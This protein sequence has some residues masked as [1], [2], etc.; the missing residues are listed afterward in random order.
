MRRR[1][2]ILYLSVVV[3]L[4][5][6]CGCSTKKYKGKDVCELLTNGDIAGV[7]GEPFKKGY[8]TGLIDEGENYVGSD[9]YFDSEARAPDNPKEPK[10]RVRVEVTYVET[11]KASVNVTR[12]EWETSTYNGKPFY[13]DIHDVTG[14]GDAAVAAT[15][16]NRSLTIWSLIKPNTKLEV[17]VYNVVESQAEDRGVRIARKMFSLLQSGPKPAE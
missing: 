4:A 5:S 7:M 11:A 10:F 3:L 16:Y 17:G 14:I 1:S 2:R 13:T 12:K 6:S 8:R 15:G 9:C